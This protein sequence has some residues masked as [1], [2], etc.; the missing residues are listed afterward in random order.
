[1]KSILGIV[2]DDEEELASLFTQF[3]KLIYKLLKNKFL[4][5]EYNK[6]NNF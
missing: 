5:F 1:M 3:S 6:S 2:V 4:R